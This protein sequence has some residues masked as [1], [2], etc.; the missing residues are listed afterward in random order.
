MR[1]RSSVSAFSGSRKSAFTLVELLVVIAI[2]GILI[3]LLLPAV[4]AAREA[5]RRMQCT[6]NLKQWALGMHMYHDTER[7]LPVGSIAPLPPDYKFPPRKTWVIF[8]WPYI[9]Q[10]QLAERGD[11]AIPFYLPPYSV[12]Y[13]HD[14]LTG[15]PVA[16]YSCPSDSG[17][18][19]TGCY[20]ARRR[21][22][23][24]INWGNCHYGQVNE[25]DSKAPFSHAKGDRSYPRINKFRD[26]TDGL[27]S[28]LLMSETLKGTSVEDDDWRGDILNDDGVFRFHT[29]FT[30]NTSAPDVTGRFHPNGDPL[31][32]AV[33]GGSN[34]EISA[35]RSRHPGGVNAAMCDGSIRF[36]SNYV[37]LK[38]WMG[39]GTMNGSEVLNTED[40]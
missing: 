31:M 40:E 28:T 12:P 1:V 27:T 30:P 37:S 20:Y 17:A 11:P 21:G 8:M 29:L 39:Q 15:Q 18:D 26:I 10:T 19:L 35:A 5:A 23:Y 24:V 33:G 25:P 7:I 32:P 38:L 3:A 4:Q 36:V 34:A 16:L 14:G 6:N 2:I 13:T 22:N 9:E